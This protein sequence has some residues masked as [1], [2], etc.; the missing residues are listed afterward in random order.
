[1]GQPALRL[2]PRLNLLREFYL[3]QEDASLVKLILRGDLKAQE[4]LIKRHY[5]GIYRAAYGILGEH[6]GALDVTQGLFA[7]LKRVL[8]CY[9]GR[10]NLKSY[11]Y[12]AGV[13]AALDELRR[14]SR[15]P[16]TV[17]LEETAASAGVSDRAM[18]ASEV[19]VR[20]LEALPA[21]QRAALVL[22]DLQELSTDETAQALGISASGVRTLLSE[23]RLRLRQVIERDFPEYKDWSG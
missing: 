4:E 9:D 11:L 15:W 23:A 21:R 2:Q 1:M 22:R 10:S 7:R 19:L 8:R 6:H 17:A 14:R 20:A 16:Q 13:N 3:A 18:Q 5:P 12:R